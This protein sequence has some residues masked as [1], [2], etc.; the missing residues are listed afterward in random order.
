[1][2]A[3]S[4]E[5]LSS[6]LLGKGKPRMA[7]T[8]PRINVTVNGTVH[9]REIEPRMLLAHFLRDTLNLTGTHIG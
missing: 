5:H 1:M 8:K 2:V 9:E 4:F 6:R 7:T 3:Q